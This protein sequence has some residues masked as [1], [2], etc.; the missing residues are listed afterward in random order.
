MA[1]AQRPTETPACRAPAGIDGICVSPKAG[2]F[3]ARGMNSNW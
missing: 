3:Y 1:E 2:A